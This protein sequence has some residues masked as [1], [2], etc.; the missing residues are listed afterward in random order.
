MHTE[1]GGVRMHFNDND[2]GTLEDSTVT[3]VPVTLLSNSIPAEVSLIN[4]QANEEG[5]H[6]ANGKRF[7]IFVVPSPDGSS[8]TFC[9][10]LIGQGGSF[11]TARNC[12]TFHHH[13]SVKI[14]KPGDIYVA[15]S[16]TTAFVTPTITMEV[17]DDDVLNT[18]KTLTLLLPAWNEKFFI[19]TAA[20]SDVPESSAAME[21]Q[22]TFYHTKA[23]NFRTP[24][25]Q[26]RS[27]NDLLSPAPSLLD[28]SIYSPFFKD[29]EV[30]PITDIDHISGVLARLDGGIT[31]NNAAII[32]F[33]EDY[34]G[35]HGKA[36]N[37]I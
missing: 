22:E 23:L 27:A 3:G 10:Q 7:K 25:K 5:T 24:A 29:D 17:I 18:S 28:V 6:G 19:A 33:I 21:V 36:G 11:C 1:G 4:G 16:P 20:S 13:A 35:E 37:S 34:K 15:K 31:L 12:S 8:S 26:K 14:V 32:N 9:F 30:A 2:Q